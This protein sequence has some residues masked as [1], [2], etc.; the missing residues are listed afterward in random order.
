MLR[1]LLTLSYAQKIFVLA[2]IPLLVATL[3]ILLVVNYQTRQLSDQELRA[4]EAELL[5]AK[6]AELKNYMSLARTAIGPVYG[7]AGPFDDH[8]KLLAT[9]TL[10]ALVY[11]RDGFFFVYDYDGN[12][13]V[14]PRETRLIGSNW[15]DLINGEDRS[16]VQEIL[17][18]ARSGGGYLRYEWTK[19]STGEQEQMV[20]Y[21]ISLPDWRW[22][23]GTGIFIDDVI[24][25]MAAARAS[26][27]AR[28]SK[29]SWLIMGITL[30][31]LALVFLSGMVI[32]IRERRLADAKLKDLTA[33][34]FETQEEERIRVSRELHD[35]I[36][37]VLVSVRYA[38]ELAIRRMATGDTRA[39][40][41]VVKGRDG[42]TEAITEVRRISRDLRPGVLDDLG[43]GPALG[44]LTDDFSRRTGIACDFETV[45]FR[46]R[47]N[48]EA[49]TAL[50]RVA[51]EAL[52]N[53]ERHAQANQVTL[54]A[55]PHRR[56]ATL[57]ITDNGIGIGNRTSTGHGLRNMQERIEYLGGTLR[58]LSSRSGTVIEAEVPLA[59][60][61]N[62]HTEFRTE[63]A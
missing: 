16:V 22:A 60:V 47:L 35:G 1:N 3:A 51:Q 61:L 4:L 48:A 28:I 46:N 29:T 27:E 62:P 10:S 2:S 15:I 49:K 33:R 58:V 39:E 31:M 5:A 30:A 14:S 26:T 25:N 17:T 57:R 53:V 36:S 44:A 8:A 20:T 54:S 19:P 55:R 42:L 7:N 41:S 9:Q 37:Q 40:E 45:P 56:G 6:E 24:A 18:K 21:V 43:L 38:L 63:S 34:I 11:G 59:Q 13:L 32:N 50:Y 23:I 52:T 12:N